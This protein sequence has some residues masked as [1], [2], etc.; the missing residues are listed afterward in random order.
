MSVNYILDD[1]N[2]NVSSTMKHKR[3]T[4]LIQYYEKI[5]KNE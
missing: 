1:S 5:D 3:Q 4:Y 2:R